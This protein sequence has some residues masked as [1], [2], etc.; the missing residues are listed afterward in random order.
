MISGGRRKE[1]VVL[2]LLSTT[3]E[4]ARNLTRQ[5]SQRA[6][7]RVMDEPAITLARLLVV[8]LG[9]VVKERQRDLVQEDG[10]ALRCTSPA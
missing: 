4:H 9:S 8:Y 10:W 6:L 7:R 1:Q 5:T 2:A 3:K